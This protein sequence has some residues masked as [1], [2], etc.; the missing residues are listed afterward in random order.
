MVKFS[1]YTYFNPDYTPRQ[2]FQQGIMDGMYFRPIYSHVTNKNYKDDYK[3]FKFLK[4]IPIQKL[5][6]GVWDPKINKYKIHAS[7]TLDEWEKKHWIHPNSPRGWISWYCHFYN[8]RRTLD[9]ERQI[10][11]FL[12]IL[13]RFAQRKNKTPKIKQVLL[14]W[15]IDGNKLH[16][17]YIKKIKGIKRVKSSLI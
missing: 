1:D 7:Q 14:H 11:R 6:N 15:A 16:T 3:E 10:S 4:G 13:T 17:E 2:M 9:D 8:G 12:G 5:N